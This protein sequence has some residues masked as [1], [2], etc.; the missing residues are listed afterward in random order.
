MTKGRGR[1]TIDQG[2][3]TPV[4]LALEDIGGKTGD[5]WLGEEVTEW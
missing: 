5:F 4:M 1:K 2:A 3:K